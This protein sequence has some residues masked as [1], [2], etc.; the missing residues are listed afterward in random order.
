MF[1][2]TRANRIK[3]VLNTNV[4]VSGYF[5]TRGASY[6]ILQHWQHSAFQLV[7]SEEIVEEIVE[8]FSELDFSSDVIDNLVLSIYLLGVVT[9]GLYQV[10]A[11]LEDP[12]DNM[13]LAAALEGDAD[14]IVSFDTHLRALKH[15]HG[16]QIVSPSQ[17]L[18]ILRQQEVNE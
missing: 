17:F 14:F 16:I 12:D 3:A 18:K 15:Y 13:F 8:K 2:E 7:I 9:E 4:F 6:E 1:N 11:V 10:S 5:S